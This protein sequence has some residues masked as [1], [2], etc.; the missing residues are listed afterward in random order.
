MRPVLYFLMILLMAGC[1]SAS[2]KKTNPAVDDSLPP[3]TKTDTPQTYIHN[4]PDSVL[5][6]KITASLMKLPFII[7][8]DRYIDSL[9]NHKHGIAFMLDSTGTGGNEVSVQAGYNGEER[10]ETYYRFFVNPKTMDIKVYDAVTD[11]SMSV[12]AFI[13]SQQKQ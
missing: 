10:F 1:N 9:S 7:K 4:F 5:E 13:K 8:A 11:S 6:S 12:K 2:D 3:P